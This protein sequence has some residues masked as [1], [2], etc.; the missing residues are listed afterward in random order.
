MRKMILTFSLAIA[1]ESAAKNIES[2]IERWAPYFEQHAWQTMIEDYAP[3]ATSCGI[4][5]ELP[6]ALGFADEGLAIVDM[7]NL[8][9]AEPHY[10]PDNCYEI[11]FV[12]QGTAL[13]VI[14]DLEQQVKVG[15]IIIVPPNK[16]HYTIPD[17]EYVIG[18]INT[19][20]YT[21]ESYIPLI[22]SR[23]DVA[24]DAQRF[25][26]LTHQSEI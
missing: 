4:V 5:Y 7:R 20:P 13:V 15:D 18:V 6:N 23:E 22:A 8:A 14:A 19:P 1:H 11:Y 3:I 25:K 9:V 24:F 16:A 2:L 12:L 10:H 26:T 17:K 21:P